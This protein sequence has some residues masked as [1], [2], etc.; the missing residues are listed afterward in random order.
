MPRTIDTAGLVALLDEADPQLLEVLPASAYEAEHLPGAI[1]VA[2]PSLTREAAA[3]A[4]DRQRPVVV[5][6]YDTEC[7]LSAR[8]AALLE[9]YGFDPVYDHRG[10]KT[11]WLGL[12][13]AVEGT[14]PAAVRAGALARRD[15][16][17][18]GV[19][20]TIG[21]ARQVDGGEG[22]PV[23]VL[24]DGDVVVG[25]LRPD[26]LDGD[27]GTP[28]VDVLQPGPPTVRPSI[29]ASELALSMDEEGQD[30]VLVTLLDGRLVGLVRRRDLDLDA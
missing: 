7:D 12:G 15:V 28:V 29:T 6:C 30:H 18:V 22:E 23:V 21:Q 17:R 20:A 26:T 3:A 5:Y 13:H 14:T 9:A 25:A 8:G 2:L 11:E 16:G 27:D 19:E 1:N 24:A 4:L 10:S